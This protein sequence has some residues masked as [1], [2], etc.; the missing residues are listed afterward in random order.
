[1]RNFSVTS[2]QQG[3]FRFEQRAKN[4]AAAAQD[5]EARQHL[6]DLAAAASAAEGTL[7]GLEDVANGRT[8]PARPDEM[9]AGYD[10]CR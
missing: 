7:R 4:A 3:G 5:A 9:R 6:P 2:R 8:R 1:V 10:I